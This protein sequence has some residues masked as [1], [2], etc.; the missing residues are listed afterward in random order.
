MKIIKKNLIYLRLFSYICCPI[1][2]SEKSAT[3]FLC[4]IVDLTLTIEKKTIAFFSSKL[5]IKSKL[6]VVS[7]QG[8]HFWF[9]LSSFVSV[10][11]RILGKLTVCLML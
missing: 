5:G 10:I 7:V 1:N 2:A 8:G 6:F 4:Q 3:L 9:R 11:Q